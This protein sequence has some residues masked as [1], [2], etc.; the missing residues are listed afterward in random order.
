MVQLFLFKEN[1]DLLDLYERHIASLLIARWLQATLVV[2]KADIFSP[3]TWF[4]W[5]HFEIQKI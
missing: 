5:T 2:D 3:F 1:H 4:H